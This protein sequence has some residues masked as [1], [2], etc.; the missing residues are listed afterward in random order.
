MTETTTQQTKPT[1]QAV[2]PAEQATEQT[3]TTASEQAQ[4]AASSEEIER[5][6]LQV[7]LAEAEARKAEAEAQKARAAA[8]NAQ[9][10]IAEAEARAAQAQSCYEA[11]HPS[12]LQQIREDEAKDPQR[13][14]EHNELTK[15]RRPGCLKRMGQLAA[16]VC[17]LTLGMSYA[18][19]CI[20]KNSRVSV[21]PVAVKK[22]T[23]KAT[24]NNA[25][26]EGL[27]KTLQAK[28]TWRSEFNASIKNYTPAEQEA[29]K[30]G[31]TYL[32]AFQN[33]MEAH[34]NG[35]VSARDAAKMA[36]LDLEGKIKSKSRPVFRVLNKMVA[37]MGQ[38]YKVNPEYRFE[39]KQLSK[40]LVHKYELS[41]AGYARGGQSAER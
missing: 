29:L 28:E 33:F 32:G 9:S 22:M 41:T 37:T 3:Q 1:E 17:F 24:Q 36:V 39:M 2:K 6:K 12:L 20:R 5:L 14:K 35:N 23:P 30:M 38:T 34:R 40:E 18:K 13:W 7:R 27:Q 4:A 11:H 10:Q 15:P 31:V 26:T 8:T 21:P 25:E 19:S 16:I